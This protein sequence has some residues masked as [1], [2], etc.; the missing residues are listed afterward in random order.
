[1]YT[2][3]TNQIVEDEI[4]LKEL[5]SK[6]WGFK[7]F[8]IRI[9]LLASLLITLF[10]VYKAVTQPPIYEYEA[11]S[12]LRVTLTTENAQPKVV[13]VNM[14]SSRAI[15]EEITK[16][17]TLTKPLV[18]SMVTVTPIADSDLVRFSVIYPDKDKAILI[19]NEFP[20]KVSALVRQTVRGVTLTHDEAVL[21]GVTKEIRGSTNVALYSVVGVVLGGMLA[22]FIVFL[23]EY[24]LGKVSTKKELQE[25]LGVEV[26]GEIINTVEV[27]RNGWWPWK[28]I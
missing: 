6:L 22:L 13:V 27:K 17:L 10:G 21:T 11:E 20:S 1:M 23:M 24:L 4:D 19:A 8:I 28:R 9:T 14:L 12:H 5:V 7:S 15:G 16:Q 18:S 26:L 2:E 25:N 3:Y